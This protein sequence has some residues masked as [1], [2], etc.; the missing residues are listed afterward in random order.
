[1]VFIL[2]CIGVQFVGTA[3]IDVVTDERLLG[4]IADAWA[5]GRAS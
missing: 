1:M 4:A 5:R 3:V 2:V